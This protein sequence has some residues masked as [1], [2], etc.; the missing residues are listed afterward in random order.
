MSPA[1]ASAGVGVGRCDIRAHANCLENLPV[2]GAV[3]V[4]VVATGADS[5]QLDMAA[6]IFL[7][8]RMI[9]TVIHVVFT[10]TNAIAS[11]RFAFFFA[12]IVCMFWMGIWLVT[13]T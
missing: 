2:Y 9:Q 4:A 3:V 11:A 10:P 13:S 8:A 12:Q 5:P 7:A 1:R 6:V